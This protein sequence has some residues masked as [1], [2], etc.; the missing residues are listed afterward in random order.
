MKFG[1]FSVAFDKVNNEYKDQDQ[2]MMGLQ[3]IGVECV[4]ISF[5]DKISNDLTLPL[6]IRPIKNIDDLPNVAED[7]DCV[8]GH[9][10]GLNNVN[11][12]LKLKQLNKILIYKTDS[13]GRFCYEEEYNNRVMD[14][15][16]VY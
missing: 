1:M 6:E 7:L 3:E 11:G 16:A 8:I 4:I 2:I 5:Q 10:I 15:Y 9:N 14:Y 13:D 12:F